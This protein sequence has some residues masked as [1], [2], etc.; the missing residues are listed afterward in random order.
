MWLTNPTLMHIEDMCDIIIVTFIFQLHIEDVWHHH[1]DII[2]IFQLH[3]EDIIIVTSLWYFN[4]TSKT[5]VTSSLWHHCDISTAWNISLVSIVSAWNIS[6]VSIVSLCLW[7][8]HNWAEPQRDVS[9]DRQSDMVLMEWWHHHPWHQNA[10][11]N[12]ATERHRDD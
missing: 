1:C 3:I 10:Y 5:C 9:G 7:W 8:C 6:L 11:C 12:R 4:C 2:V